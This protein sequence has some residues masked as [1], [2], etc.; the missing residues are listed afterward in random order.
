MKI[1]KKVRCTFKG[2]EKDTFI[3]EVDE[4]GWGRCG[5]AIVSDDG[6][7]FCLWIKRILEWQDITVEHLLK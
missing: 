4:Q 1:P 7:D 6:K 2:G 3:C 5:D